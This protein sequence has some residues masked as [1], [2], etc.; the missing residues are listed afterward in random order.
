MPVADWS[1][2]AVHAAAPQ[3]SDE[4]QGGLFFPGTGHF[5]DPY[6]VVCELVNAAKAH[7]VQFIKQHVVDGRLAPEGVSL[8]TE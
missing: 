4:I 3:L 1:G 7:G 8:L 5:V 2:S 6:T